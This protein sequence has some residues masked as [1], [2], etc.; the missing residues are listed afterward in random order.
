MRTIRLTM[1]Q[2]LLRFLDS[3]YVSFDGVEMK[4]V[5]GVM[6]IFGHGNVTGIGEALERSPGSLAY[7]QGKNEQGMAHAA[8][9]F[10][11]QSRRRRI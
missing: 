4:F 8:I 2:A 9:A 1:A 3:Q 5:A 6:G 10:A 7:V 11:K